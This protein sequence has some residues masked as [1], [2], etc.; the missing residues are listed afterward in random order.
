MNYYRP[1]KSLCKRAA[2]CFIEKYIHLARDSY[3]KCNQSR[4]RTHTDAGQKINACFSYLRRVR[5]VV[6]P[7]VDSFPFNIN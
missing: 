3:V 1:R 6:G 7:I 5:K 2:I 4:V